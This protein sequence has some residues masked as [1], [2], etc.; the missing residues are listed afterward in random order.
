MNTERTGDGRQ[1]DVDAEKRVFEAVRD[2]WEKDGSHLSVARA[3]IAALRSEPVVAMTP[4]RTAALFNAADELEHSTRR[5]CLPDA[6]T[7]RAMIA[8]GRERTVARN[9]PSEIMLTNAP[10]GDLSEALAGFA[11]REVQQ[12]LRGRDGVRFEELLP[13]AGENAHAAPTLIREADEYVRASLQSGKRGVFHIQP[14]HGSQVTGEIL[15][16]S[17][18]AVYVYAGR[19]QAQS[20]P[21][22]AVKG[23]EERIEDGD[24]RPG[25][26]ARTQATRSRR[27]RGCHS[28]V[29]V[30]T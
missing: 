4:E 19:G 16:I 2:A 14:F 10:S 20:V 22:E 18:D 15:A 5:G 26:M 13:K 3:A 9:E 1:G 21:I 24:L 23:L 28:C 30:R 8:E 11:E 7:I 12:S 27:E 29:F 6:A 17:R 25:L